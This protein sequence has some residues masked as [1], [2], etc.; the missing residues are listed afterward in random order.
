MNQYWPRLSALIDEAMV[1]P[2]A[3]QRAFVAAQTEGDPDF[4]TAAFHFIDSLHSG[5][6]V[7]MRTGAMGSGETDRPP[8]LTQGERIG[9]W[10]ITGLIGEGGMGRVYAVDRV[11]GGFT[12]AGALK[13]NDA[14]PG[15]DL[16]VITQERQVLA[17][18]D[19]PSIARILDG[20]SLPDGSSWMVMERIEGPTI[21]RWCADRMLGLA[22]RVRLV[23][24]TADGLAQ[25]HAR[26]VL[27]RDLKP[28][29]I[30]VDPMGQPRLI[31]FG[32]ARRIGSLDPAAPE[33]LSLA[34]AA[35]EL[36]EGLSVGPASD[37][38]GL[39]QVL[40]ELLTGHPAQQRSGL[41]AG[42]ALAVGGEAAVTITSADLLPEVARRA[43][44][45]I[46][47]DVAA[48]LSRALQRDPA[49]R[50]PTI[51]AFASDLRRALDGRA[52]EARAH[53]PGYRF[54]RW[55]V[56]FK[57]PVAGAVAIAISLTGGLGGALWQAREAKAARDA[58]VVE[59][60][61][62]EAVRQSLFLVLGEST[63]AAGP[64]GSRKDV[65]DRASERLTREF[66]RD[67][68]QYA[69]VLKALGELYFH[70]NDYPGAIG[71][72]KPV[73]SLPL[74]GAAARVS[75][76]PPEVIAEAKVDL[77]Q[78]YLRTG[79][80]EQARTLLTT[81][82]AFWASDPVR[83]E[84][85]MIESRLA[86][87]QIVRD[88]DKDPP[89]AASILRRALADRIAM[90]GPANRDVAIFQNNLGN[91]LST[92]GQHDEAAA[93]F[94]QAQATW[95]AI[96]AS[97]T[98]DAMNTLNNLAASEVL[99]GRPAAAVPQFAEA[100]RLRRALFGP[101]AA[102]AALINNHAKTLLLSGDAAQALP[103]A[104]EAMAMAGEFAGR[105][106]MLHAASAAGLSEALLETGQAKDALAAAI[107]G[108]SAALQT[109]GA[110]TPPEIVA[111]IALARATAAS[112]SKDAARGQLVSAEKGVAAM[113]PAGAR[114]NDAIREIRQRYRL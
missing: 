1:L 79:E 38:Y 57:W 6:T 44:S 64:D 107:S 84:S 95:A 45:A 63:E 50:Y 41:P 66:A 42:V 110:G 35:P 109:S 61:R 21:D 36:L 32:I 80:P 58:A 65:L 15:T 14:L 39:A 53:E 27:H 75:K 111:L 78:V 71:L 88:L 28:S 90:S 114:L 70:S 89:R 86:E 105:G 87:A 13:L 4:Q 73:A 82:Q 67:P 97:E 18:L 60:D 99:A 81:A 46:L 19:H 17:D 101:S 5:L 103:L 62:T 108:H 30:L 48:V 23:L 93:S 104:R 26:L 37:V 40:H 55:L 106:S 43:P 92:M 22:D 25:A 20:G 76:V 31:D 72:L 49:A 94:R 98:P 83:W 69:P 102:L 77:A 100:V 8:P 51:D 16:L 112:G 9:V 29:N 47:G 113:G 7:F 96:G 3:D 91:V 56:R 59:A 74:S 85:D 24:A 2:L 68:A 52:V 12:Q 33:R 11:E 10:E 34:Y 54:R